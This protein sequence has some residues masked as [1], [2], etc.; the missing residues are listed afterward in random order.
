MKIRIPGKSIHQIVE[1]LAQLTRRR[2]V[3]VPH[4]LAL[5]LVFTTESQP[6][7]KRQSRRQN[8]LRQ[9]CTGSTVLVEI[10]DEE[11]AHADDLSDFYLTFGVHTIHVSTHSFLDCPE[12]YRPGRG[13]ITS[14]SN[15][16][17]VE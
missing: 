5:L 6:L 4:F 15:D 8:Q 1:L 16:V 9:R 7:I 2:T 3:L 11:I 17:P 12:A 10:I 14:L 13:F